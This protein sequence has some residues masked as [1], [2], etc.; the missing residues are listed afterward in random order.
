MM[1]DKEAL[2]E[3]KEIKMEENGEIKVEENEEIKVE[4]NEEIKVEE[5]EEIK[6]EEN[7]DIKSEE[8]REVK[9][10]ENKDIKVEENKEIKVVENKEI[11]VVET[12]EVKVENDILEMPR[13]PL[14]P[15]SFVCTF[16]DEE[17]RVIRGVCSAE[18]V[19]FDV[20]EE[21]Y[22]SLFVLDSHSKSIDMVQVQRALGGRIF[23]GQG[24]AKAFT[25]RGGHE[26]RSYCSSDR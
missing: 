15:R 22:D 2:E 23:H 5:N 19:P 7:K 13:S 11:K 25:K 20:G 21:F 16:G 3:N 6:V 12:S 24:S 17:T 4:E 14:G 10:E 26:R 18:P 8:K 9:V 1:V